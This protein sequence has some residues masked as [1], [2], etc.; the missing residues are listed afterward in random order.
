MFGNLFNQKKQPLQPEA[1]SQMSVPVSS[2][3]IN[4]VNQQAAV[5][6]QGVASQ[7]D[8]KTTSPAVSRINPNLKQN[9]SALSHLDQRSTQV[10]QHAQE[11]TKRIR[12]QLIEPDQ[13]LIGL[14]YDADLFKLLEEFSVDPAKLTKEIQTKEVVGTFT[15]QPTLSDKSKQVFEQSYRDAKTRESSFVTPEDILLSLFND[16]LTTAGQLK[17]QGINKEEVE[18]KLSKAHGFSYGKKSVLDRFGIDLTEQAREGK[19]DPIAGRDKEIDR[20]VHILLRRTKNNPIIIGEAGVGKTAII[21]GLAEE[22]VTGKSPKE[23]A[24]KRIIQLDLSSIVAGASHR[25]EFEER[26][27]SVIQESMASAGQI[28]LFIDE[29]HILMGA[30]GD[31]DSMNAS[32]IIKPHLARGQLQIIGATTTSEY[33]K[34]FEKDKALERRFQPVVA[35]EPS[36]EAAI[37]MLK[38]LRPK[39]ERFHNVTISDK[40]IEAAVKLSK[41][42]IGERYLPDKAVDLLDEAS[43]WVKLGRSETFLPRIDGGKSDV[44]ELV[45]VIKTNE[46]SKVNDKTDET[47]GNKETN[48]QDMSQNSIANGALPEGNS[49]LAGSVATP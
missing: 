30:G 13:L 38:V 22:I 28:I 21:E 11:E 36:E 12:Q 19:L 15:G 4:N 14:L 8:A 39:Y 31:G 20:L 49:N 46:D 17:Q 43:A 16:T 23:L 3:S 48:T 24:N 26:L 47:T 27:R 40:T 10:L 32:N 41:K 37:E 5:T 35:E 9:L 33:R 6:P 25:G 18:T 7:G 42:Y 45:Q 2:Q 34:N 29:I 44:K 1:S